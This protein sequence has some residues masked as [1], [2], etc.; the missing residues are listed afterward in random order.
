MQSNEHAT[1]YKSAYRKITDFDKR[2]H[3]S[4]VL[5]TE[6]FVLKRMCRTE[7]AT[8]RYLDRHRKSLSKNKT[9]VSIPSLLDYDRH[10][11]LGLLTNVGDFG[12]PSLSEYFGT[13]QK[14][15]TA[16]LS[17]LLHSFTIVRS[18]PKPL[19]LNNQSDY[20]ERI[21]SII[22]SLQYLESGITG[23]EPTTC[24]ALYERV[25]DFVNESQEIIENSPLFPSHRDPNPTN[26]I[27]D[28]SLI[29]IIDWETFG[30]SRIGYDEGRLYT[31][32]A[33]N[34]CLQKKFKSML[35]AKF[36][37]REEVYFWRV[38]ACRSFREMVSIIN[39]R[40]DMRFRAQG[41]IKIS[42]AEKQIVLSSLEAT[43]IHAV[44]V[45][46][47]LLRK[48]QKDRN[49]STALHPTP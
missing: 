47:T 38:V 27:V 21:N 40:Y 9:Q 36:T 2:L 18:L 39:G 15:T 8:Y 25:F 33:L 49:R 48:V 37:R 12:C 19:H 28:E 20:D 35:T 11:G 7:A 6:S 22:S 32:L 17:M 29:K 23:N 14:Y 44:K 43:L 42:L 24:I 46:T 13:S 26:F 16:Y 1:D 4:K 31:Y 34:P 41:K 30:L 10:Q 3:Y 5:V 45:G